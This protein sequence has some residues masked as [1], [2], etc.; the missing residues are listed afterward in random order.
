MILDTSM[1]GLVD[2]Y[3]QPI[4]TAA[5]EVTAEEVAAYS[6]QQKVDMAKQLI[7]IYG[8]VLE[9]T[10]LSKTGKYIAKPETIN[11]IHQLHRRVSLFDPELVEDIAK[12]A[13]N[14]TLPITRETKLRAKLQVQLD[15]LAEKCQQKGMPEEKARKLLEK[16]HEAF[17]KS[18]YGKVNKPKS[19]AATR[20]AQ[21]L[22]KANKIKNM[23]PAEEIPDAPADI[24]ISF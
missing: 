3:G 24:R 1:S 16:K 21:R 11:K 14:K 9:M 2:V 8:F 4:I 18:H 7:N 20:M 12:Q 22:N 10:R 19:S 6:P 23:P 17:Y 15:E 5:P 13:S